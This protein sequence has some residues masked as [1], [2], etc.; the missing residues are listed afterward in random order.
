MTFHRGEE[1]KG[2]RRDERLAE[3]RKAHQSDDEQDHH[4]HRRPDV[5]HIV[6]QRGEH[7]EDRRIWET[8]REGPERDDDAERGVDGRHDREIA[9]QISFDVGHDLEEAQLGVAG[10]E[11]RDELRAQLDLADKKEHQR[12]EEQQQLAGCGRHECD[13]R[14]H[15]ARGGWRRRRRARA[16]QHFFQLEQ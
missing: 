9:G 7:A 6:Q 4:H 1:D 8:K 14:Q 13:H 3:R 11:E 2:K 10:G 12:A 15:D 16:E 5:G